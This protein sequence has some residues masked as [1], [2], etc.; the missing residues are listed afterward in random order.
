MYTS[1]NKIITYLK[2]SFYNF[3]TKEIFYSS[4]IRDLHLFSIFFLIYI[5]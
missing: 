1:F 2:Q 4:Y 5:L 3:Q